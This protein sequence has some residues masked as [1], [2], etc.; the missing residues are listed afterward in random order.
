ME[1]K[2]QSVKKKNR[3]PREGRN[4]SVEKRQSDVTRDYD[5][6]MTE[7]EPLHA[8]LQSLK[9]TKEQKARIEE[10]EQ[11]ALKAWED[12]KKAVAE[13]FW[14]MEMILIRP[15]CTAFDD[16]VERST[17]LWYRSFC[18][19]S[20]GELN[21]ADLWSAMYRSNLLYRPI[22]LACSRADQLPFGCRRGLAPSATKE[23]SA[24][25]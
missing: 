17:W 22:L 4:S 7:L 6:L 20:A 9:D 11:A 18:L 25:S 21:H 3:I 8:E 15:V 5:S 14:K 12:T 23:C 1:R 13:I 2:K 16:V 10:S 19:E 24:I